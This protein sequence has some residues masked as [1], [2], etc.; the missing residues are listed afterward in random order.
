VTVLFADVKGSMDLAEEIDL[1]EWHRIMDWFF[2]TLADGVYRSKA[3]S[4]NT[5]ATGRVDE[6]VSLETALARSLAVGQ[7]V[8]IGRPRNRLELSRSRVPSTLPGSG[9]LGP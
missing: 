1:Q 9:H 5:R 3:Q 4:I 8:G 7:V 2:R 6:M